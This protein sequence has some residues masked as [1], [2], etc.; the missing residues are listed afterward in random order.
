[1]YGRA[2]GMPSFQ[3]TVAVREKAGKW[4]KHNLLH[5]W[6]YACQIIK[7]SEKRGVPVF[8]PTRNTIDLSVQG[9]FQCNLTLRSAHNDPDF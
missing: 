4:M 6:S 9:R 1:M 7:R 3:L 8:S 5:C 2:D